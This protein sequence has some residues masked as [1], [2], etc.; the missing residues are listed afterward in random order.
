MAY[1]LLFRHPHCDFRRCRQRAEVTVTNL[2]I[3]LDGDYCGYHG[4]VL[5]ETYDV[6]LTVSPPPAPRRILHWPG[7]LSAA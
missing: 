4:A 6:P 7:E 3:G 2:R 5:Q 1:T